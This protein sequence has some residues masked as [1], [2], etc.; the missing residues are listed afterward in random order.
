MHGW[1]YLIRVAVLGD[2]LEA[3]FCCAQAGIQAT[4]AELWIHLTLAI[5][6]RFNIM[7]QMWQVG[8]GALVITG[9]EDIETRETTFQVMRA[10]AEGRMVPAERTC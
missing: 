2:E 4:C 8:F 5:D 10:F 1:S 7:Q 9:R 6:D 3:E